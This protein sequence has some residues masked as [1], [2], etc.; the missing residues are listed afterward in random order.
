[1]TLEGSYQGLLY[2]FIPDLTKLF[3]ANV[4]IKACNQVIFMISLGTGGNIMFSSYRRE[5]E[6]IYL[7][8]FWIPM[9]T[10]MCA[11]MCAIINFCYLGHLS[12]ILDI[13][14]DDL[15]L[16][17]T[18]LAFITY[19]SAL[20]YLP[21]PNLWSVMFFFMLITLGIDSQVSIRC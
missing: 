9:I 5:G 16:K 11:L 10:V 14:I 3:D 21:Y 13:P 8:S 19:P 17:G 6:D 15:P 7:S 12:F 20:N 1:M 2:L 4:W 18:D